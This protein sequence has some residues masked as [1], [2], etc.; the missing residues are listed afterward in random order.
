MKKFLII[1]TSSLGD[2]I[3][4]FPVLEYLKSRFPSSQIDWI[5]ESSG[6]DLLMTH[7]C[8]NRVITI[9][10]KKWRSSLFNR[11]HFREIRQFKRELQSVHYDAIFDLQGNLKSSLLTYLAKGGDKVGFGL[12]SVHEWPNALFTSFQ[13]NPPKGVNI[14]ED[15][16]SIVQQY[17]NDSKPRELKYSL[18]HTSEKEKE[19]LQQ[20]LMPL[21]KEIILVCPG[22]AWKNKQMDKEQLFQFLSKVN[23]SGNYNFLLAWGTNEEKE[24]VTSLKE[25]IGN[26]ALVLERLSFPLLQNLMARVHLIIAMDSLPL[27]LAGTTMTPTF[28]VFGS[29]LAQ[30]FKPMGPQHYAIQGS[31]PYGKTFEKRCAIL[32]TCSTGACIRS[33]K[34]EFVFQEFQKF[35]E[36]N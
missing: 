27:H 22:S 14:R 16:L 20:L 9:Q 6:R 23:Q 3:Q 8:I 35:R 4:S 26:N 13:Y 12:R 30:K 1:K 29:S 33:L 18:L 32:R 19:F 21:K 31:C 25:S 15:Y 17:C 34:G 10:T 28:S 24:L 5:V 11:D 36:R 2:I 7:P